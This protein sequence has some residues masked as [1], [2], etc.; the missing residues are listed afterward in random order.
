M[1]FPEKFAKVLRTPILPKVDWRLVLKYLLKIKIAPSD[2]I[3]E[4]DKE[5]LLILLKK[6]Q[7]YGKQSTWIKG[8][9]DVRISRLSLRIF[10]SKKLRIS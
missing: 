1:C 6:K 8:S 5:K 2:K 10:Q 4:N 7:T 3:L 9:E